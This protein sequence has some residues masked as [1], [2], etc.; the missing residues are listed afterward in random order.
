MY[1]KD[2][3][4]KVCLHLVFR[5]NIIIKERVSV[6]RRQSHRL[7]LLSGNGMMLQHVWTSIGLLMDFSVIA[8]CLVPSNTPTVAWNRDVKHGI[9]IHIA[10]A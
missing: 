2:M 10:A 9:I 6:A 5:V 7:S 4:S 8:A 3:V 1:C